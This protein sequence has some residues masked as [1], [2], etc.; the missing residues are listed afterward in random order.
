MS[1]K[2]KH[3]VP[4]SLSVVNRYLQS[5]DSSVIKNCVQPL[6]NTSAFLFSFEQTDNNGYIE[7]NGQTEGASTWNPECTIKMQY[8]YTTITSLYIRSAETMLL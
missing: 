8:L 1:I 6:D 2:I 4:I 3:Q 5:L 7:I